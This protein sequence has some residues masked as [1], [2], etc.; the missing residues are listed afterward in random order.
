MYIRRV[1][2]KNK[3]G[4]EVAYIQLAHNEWDS[5][6]QYSKAH[7]IYSFGREDQLDLAVL[8]RLADSVNR[9]L[10]PK[11]ALKS[12]AQIEKATDICI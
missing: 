2:R 12:K 11:R 10:G 7:V 8:E 3:D 9:F 1:K 6:K 5:E 4:S